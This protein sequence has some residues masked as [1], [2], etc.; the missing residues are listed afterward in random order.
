VAGVPEFLE[1]GLVLTSIG[2]HGQ[3]IDGLP[4]DERSGTVPNTEGRV[5][6]GVYVTGWIKRGPNGFIGSNKSDAQ[7]TVTS[8]VAD[9][10]ADLLS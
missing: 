6:P 3:P 10:N 4:F 7:Q 2:Y 9:Y 8:L 5:A 1:A